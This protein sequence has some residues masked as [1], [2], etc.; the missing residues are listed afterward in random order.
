MH[1]KRILQHWCSFLYSNLLTLRGNKPNLFAYNY[2]DLDKRCRITVGK[3]IS[4]LG[5]S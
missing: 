1:L 2:L 5:N 4:E 3:R